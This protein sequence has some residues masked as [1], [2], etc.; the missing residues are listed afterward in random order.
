MSE[1]NILTHEEAQRDPQDVA[2]LQFKA[3]LP[4]FDNLCRTLSKG[5]LKR[6]L[7][8]I[9]HSPLEDHPNLQNQAEKEA[10]AI[11]TALLDAKFMMIIGVYNEK[12][13]QT[14]KEEESKNGQ[15]N[16]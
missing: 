3:Y 12:I 13:Q 1:E 6:V 15:T 14:Q 5:S 2:A 10:F 16:T 8:A 4:R 7:T 11:G 9:I